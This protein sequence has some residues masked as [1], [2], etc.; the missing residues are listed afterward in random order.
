[1]SQKRTKQASKHTVKEVLASLE[2]STEDGKLV[3]MSPITQEFVTIEMS[4]INGQTKQ[5]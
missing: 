3:L 1:M 5:G 2:W 4:A